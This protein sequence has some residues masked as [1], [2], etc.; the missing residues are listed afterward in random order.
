[1]Y[2]WKIGFMIAGMPIAVAGVAVYLLVRGMIALCRAFAR[3]HAS[4][5]I[6]TSNRY[7]PVTSNNV[8]P[9]LRE[10][11]YLYRPTGRR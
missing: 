2:A 9:D 5:A 1:M 11:A 4:V 6:S 8:T 10:W 3:R 7:R